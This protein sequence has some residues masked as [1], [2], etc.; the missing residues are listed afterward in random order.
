MAFAFSIFSHKWCSP[1]NPSNWLEV[2][3]TY[4]TYENKGSTFSGDR[5]LRGLKTTTYWWLFSANLASYWAALYSNSK[6]HMEGLFKSTISV[7]FVCSIYVVWPCGVLGFKISF[8]WA[9]VHHLHIH[10]H[11]F[12]WS[13]DVH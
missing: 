1:S 8:L 11:F 5:Y 12:L 6:I 13:L 2:I 3:V 4:K 9:Y 7:E 10:Q